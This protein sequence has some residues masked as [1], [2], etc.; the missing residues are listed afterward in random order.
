MVRVGELWT[1]AVLNASHCALRSFPTG[2]AALREL[3]ALVLSHN[4]ISALP[5]AFPHLPELNTLVLSNNALSKL[6]ITLPSSLPSLKKLSVSHNSLTDVDALPDLSVCAHLREVRLCGNKALGQLPEHIV[7][8]GRGIDGGAPGLVLLDASDCGLDSWDAIAPL[9]RG[10]ASTSHAKQSRGLANL[11]L[12]GNRIAEAPDYQERILAAFPGLRV[13]D[14]VRLH[15]KKAAAARDGAAEDAVSAEPMAKTPPAEESAPV[16]VAEK[17]RKA[18]T[19]R[20]A[21]GPRPTKP[22][23]NSLSPEARPPAHERPAQTERAGTPEAR[24]VRKRAHDEDTESA[25]KV[26]KRS[27]RG[28][29]RRGEAKAESTPEVVSEAPAA[30]SSRAVDGGDRGPSAESTKKTRRKKKAP[31]AVEMDM[32]DHAAGAPPRVVPP[33]NAPPASPPTST[34][35]AD[36]GI[37]KVVDVARAREAPAAS[38]AALLGR[39]ADEDLG[40]W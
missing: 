11:C 26:R 16:L 38:A 30:P 7:R 6:P 15:G 33:A 10:A 21:P 28:P 37:V 3:K 19:R 24:A 4:E 29:K 34:T 36:T 25:K 40:G 35:R 22:R 1:D 5:T 18:K 27:G 23:V 14:N 12:R 39:R 8:W 9:L 32:G 13:L 2:V 20:E 31:R 17:P